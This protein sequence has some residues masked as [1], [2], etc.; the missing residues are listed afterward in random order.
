MLLSALDP[1]GYNVLPN[2]TCCFNCKINKYR[3]QG[4]LLL[5]YGQDCF[6]HKK[7]FNYLFIDYTE[8]ASVAWLAKKITLCESSLVKENGVG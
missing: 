6:S 3:K 2:Q 7:A 4:G 8:C 5:D 1:V